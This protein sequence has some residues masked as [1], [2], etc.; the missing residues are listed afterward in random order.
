[1]LRRLRKYFLK[2]VAKISLNIKSQEEKNAWYNF[3]SKDNINIHHTFA[4]KDTNI[5]KSNNEHFGNINIGERFFVRDFCRISVQ[6]SGSL[7]IGDGV[8]FNNFSSIN[9][10]D[11]I[12][13]GD[14]SIFGESVKLYDHNHEYG[15]NPDF[16]VD[17]NNYKTAPIEIGEN[18][19]IG[20]NTVIL[21]GVVIGDNT[22]VGAG[23]IIHKSIPANSIVKNKQNL[24][25]DNL[26]Q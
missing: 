12:T 20:S 22:I 17:K 13:I 26:Q 3:V 16:F 19:W 10:I 23:C 6:F 18:C 7:E 5:F 8:F 4:P 21:K 11:K 9:C 2:K 1:M 14:N 15:F 24:I 25:L